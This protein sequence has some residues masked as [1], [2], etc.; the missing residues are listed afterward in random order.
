ME[1]LL[2][3]LEGRATARTATVDVRPALEERLVRGMLTAV[4]DIVEAKSDIVKGISLTN[5][6]DDANFK[7]VWSGKR[8]AAEEFADDGSDAYLSSAGNGAAKTL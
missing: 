2:T 8:F 6:S 3:C 5:D 7:I 4:R 1:R